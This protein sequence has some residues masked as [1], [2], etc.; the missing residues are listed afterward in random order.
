MDFRKKVVYQIYPRSFNDGNNDG[1]GDLQGIIEKL[2]YLKYLGID[3][4]WLSPVYKSPD[5]DNGYD[6]SDYYDISEKFGTLD[7]FK[8]LLNEAHKRDIKIIMDLVVNHTSDE[9]KWFIES[10]SSKDNPKRD[11]YIWRDAYKNG[12]PTKQYG[13]FMEPVWTY[14]KT[15]DQYYFHN[16]AVQQPELNWENEELRHEIYKMMRYWLDMGVDGFRMDVINLISKP[17]AALVSDGGEGAS[18]IN[19]PRVHEFLQEMRKEALSH[20][21]TITVGETPGVSTEDACK[22]ANLD[23]R[24]L[25]M[26][27]QFELV[28]CQDTHGVYKWHTEKVS[29][30]NFKK[31]TEKWQNDLYNKAWNSLYLSNH[32]QPRQV[33]RYGKTD[34]KL[35]WEKSAKMLAT[36]MHFQQGTPYVYQGEEIGMTNYHISSLDDCKDYEIFSSY[37]DLVEDKKKLTHEQ[38]IAALN[39]RCR[40]HARTPVQWNDKKNAGF[41]DAEPWIAVNPNYKEINV[42]SQINDPNSI[43][44]Y[45]KKLIGLRKEVECITDGKFSLLL[46]DDPNVFAYTRENKDTKLTII[47][48][49]TDKELDMPI[50]P[51]GNLLISNYNDVTNKL[52]PYEAL[53]YMEKIK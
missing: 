13:F 4:I 7:I 53:V 16:F 42:E 14:D 34:T 28:G 18:T 5:H 35:N 46:R 8:T 36:I 2:D 1:I 40:D 25:N 44:N 11:Y 52:R 39:E 47:A 21:D 50:K 9:H 15:T 31:I 3:V 32:D 29:L 45:Y 38:M 19:G 6:I 24:E 49:Y 51:D 23:G 43:L 41:S 27:F 30:E 10:K 12:R 20:Y 48:N 22:Y 17:K 37:K 33:S 26:V